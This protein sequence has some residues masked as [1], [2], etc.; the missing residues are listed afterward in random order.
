MWQRRL[1][2]A[3]RQ[4]LCDLTPYEHAWGIRDAYE[5]REYEDAEWSRRF[6]TFLHG[7][8]WTQPEGPVALFN[9]AVGW[10][11]RHR[12]LPGV[13]VPA[14]QVSQARKVAEKRLPPPSR[15]RPAALIRRFPASWWRR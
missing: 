4:A 12:V 3:G 14:R 13:S 2:E 15:S 5:Y 8:A 9:Q 6:R 11:R 1:A 10:L 7:R